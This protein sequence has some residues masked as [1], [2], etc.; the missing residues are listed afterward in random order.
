M[1]A[2]TTLAA[3]IGFSGGVC[4]L[5][6]LL[7]AACGRWKIE[8]GPS[9][10]PGCQPTVAP[11]RNPGGIVV[12][13]NL[14]FTSETGRQSIS[15]GTIKQ[16]GRYILQIVN[17]SPSFSGH[18]LEWD[19]LSLKAADSFLWQIGQSE[20]P[21]D[22]NYTGQATDE[23]CSMAVPADCQTEFEAAAGKIDDRYF[24]KTLNDGL[25]PAIKIGFTVPPEQTGAGLV[26]T[27][28]TLYASHAPD[29]PDFKMRITLVQGP[30]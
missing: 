6:S 12:S 2:R 15:L 20:A 27:L 11:T 22:A 8:I 21:P 30:F 28:S 9:D 7:L 16:P 5:L 1:S 18:W 25:V 13:T 4:L 26:L 17:D 23:F 3:K 10:A 24:P 19:Y 14:T 29:T